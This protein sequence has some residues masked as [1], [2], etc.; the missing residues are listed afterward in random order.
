MSEKIIIEVALNNKEANALFALSKKLDLS[1]ERI[2]INALRMY[3][4]SHPDFSNVFAE[5]SK[6]NLE[7]M[8]LDKCSDCGTHPK[9]L[10]K[11][12]CIHCERL[13]YPA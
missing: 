7:R 11:S 8:L 6:R 13:N 4:D 5:L 1:T 2:M 12:I 3:H 10:G 9:I